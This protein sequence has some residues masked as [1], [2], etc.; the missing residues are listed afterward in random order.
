M[1]SHLIGDVQAFAENHVHRFSA[2]SARVL[3]DFRHHMFL[4]WRL[5]VPL[6]Q[7]AANPAGLT[8]PFLASVEP[9]YAS[10][11]CSWIAVNKLR[12]AGPTRPAMYESS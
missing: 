4:A 9:I 1:S 12:P 10:I 5:V 11:V 7:F 2:R 8:T 3:D 6:F